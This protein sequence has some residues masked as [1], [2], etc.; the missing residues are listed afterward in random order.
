MEHRNRMHIGAAKGKT[1]KPRKTGTVSDF[2]GE[3]PG[4]FPVFGLT[5][6]CG[7]R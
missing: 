1:E 7:S 3:K 4:R 2:E 6:D 5:G